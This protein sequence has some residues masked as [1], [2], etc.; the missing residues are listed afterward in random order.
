M[1]LTK[2]IAS[3]LR[4]ATTRQCPDNANVGHFYYWKTLNTVKKYFNWGDMSKDVQI[5]CK[6]CKI[7]A[8]RKTVGKTNGQRCV[9]IMM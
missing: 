6:I 7:C 9:I 2:Y 8:T 3:S 5:Y 1:K 4:K